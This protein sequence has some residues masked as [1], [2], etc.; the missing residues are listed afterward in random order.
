MHLCS[1][2]DR[3]TTNAWVDDDDDAD[4]DDDEWVG[5]QLHCVTLCSER[6]ELLDELSCLPLRNDTLRIRTKRDELEQ[7]LGKVEEAIKIFSRN[8]VY[9]KLDS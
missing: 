1:A 8:K 3:R 5:Q 7:K 9:V 2:C 6:K 4:D